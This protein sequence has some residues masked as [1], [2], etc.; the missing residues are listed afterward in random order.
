VQ[1]IT[2]RAISFWQLETGSNTLADCM[3]SRKMATNKSDLVHFADSSYPKAL[4]IL[5]NEKDLME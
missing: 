3:H 1:F 2:L 4:E 5:L